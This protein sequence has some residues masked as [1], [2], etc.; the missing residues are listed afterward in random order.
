VPLTTWWLLAAVVLGLT[1][2]VEVVLA[3]SVLALVLL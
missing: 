3:G 1:I 2:L